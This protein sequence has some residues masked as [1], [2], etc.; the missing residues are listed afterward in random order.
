V[1]LLLVGLGLT[2]GLLGALLGLGG[3]IIIVPLLTLVFNLPLTAAVGTSL[4]CVVAT[5][6]GAAAR[7]LAL[8]RTDVRLGIT[9]QGPGVVG[10]AAGG[11]LGG[12]L[13]DRLVS[14]LFAA[15]LVFAGAA[16]VRGLGVRRGV[17]VAEEPDDPTAPDGTGAPAYRGK[18]LPSAVGGSALAGGVAGL[19]GVGGGVL[20][21]PIIH[22]WMGAPMTVAV[23]TSNLIIGVTAASAAYVYLFRG[24][25]DPAVAGPV[26]LGV[27]AGSAT[28]ARVAPWIR[29][30]WL[31]AVFVVVLGYLAAR[32]ALRAIGV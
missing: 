10:A 23:A 16:M 25:V 15:V 18:R 7:Y 9:L 6:I 8:G 3:G 32:M 26:V 5:S 28:G 19:L 1:D 27:L 29:G 20:N 2:A 31:M 22:L 11:L 4:L 13:S 14:G 24:D 21:V 12:V 17:R 30:R